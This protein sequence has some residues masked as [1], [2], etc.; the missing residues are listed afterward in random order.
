[1]KIKY[2]D[3]TKSNLEWKCP[4]C[5]QYHSVRIDGKGEHNWTFNND[6]ESPTLSPS[7][8]SKLIDKD[9]N[10]RSCCHFFMVDGVISY[11][12]DCTHNLAGQSVPLPDMDNC[13]L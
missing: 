1:M 11:L 9:G 5:H 6:L 13:S 2:H 3:D 12:S 8:L 7:I 10:V 4:G